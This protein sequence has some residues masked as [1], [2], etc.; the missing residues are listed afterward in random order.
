VCST[1]AAASSLFILLVNILRPEANH[2][3][4]YSNFLVLRKVLR[5]ISMYVVKFNI[6]LAEI[7]KR[8]DIISKAL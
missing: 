4:V 1:A 3:N 6:F 2:Q 5:S 7:V 8:A